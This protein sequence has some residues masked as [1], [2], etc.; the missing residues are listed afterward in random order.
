M[1][2]ID[3][4]KYWL[5]RCLSCDYLFSMRLPPPVGGFRSLVKHLWGQVKGEPLEAFCPRC[6]SHRLDEEDVVQ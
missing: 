6:D 5:Y 4:I 1:S 3:V 2:E